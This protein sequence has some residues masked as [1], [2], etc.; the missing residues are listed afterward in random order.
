MP[1]ASDAAGPAEV[2]TYST[3]HS[4]EGPDW[5]ALICDLPEGARCY[6]RLEETPGADER[7]RRSRPS[8]SSL[9]PDEATHGPPVSA[10]LPNVV[11]GRRRGQEVRE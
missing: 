4:R 10:I 8:R 5:T 6:A 3:V 1:V 7:T 9:V 11:P 2:I